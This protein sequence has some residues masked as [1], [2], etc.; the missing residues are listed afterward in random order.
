MLPPNKHSTLR[1]HR[2]K[3]LTLT[4]RG[5]LTIRNYET[6]RKRAVTDPSPGGQQ[7]RSEVTTTV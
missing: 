5:S 3:T 7:A 1:E 6:E 4:K 2:R